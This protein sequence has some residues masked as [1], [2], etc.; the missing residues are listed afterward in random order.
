M[1]LHIAR[2]HPTPSIYDWFPRYSNSPNDPLENL[3]DSLLETVSKDSLPLWWTDH[4]YVSAKEGFLNTGA[5][6]EALRK[7]LRESRVPVIYVPDELHQHV[8]HIFNDRVLDSKQLSMF[9]LNKNSQISQWT[10]STKK[11][12]LNYL[13]SEPGFTDIG[14]LELF[15]F[16]DGTYRSIA[17]YSAFICRNQS[18]VSLFNRQ[19][20]HNIDIDKLSLAT[21]SILHEWCSGSIG[22]RS[23]SYRSASE[24]R[25]YFLEYVFKGV[26]REQDA[27][28]LDSEHAEYISQAWLW[29]IA[30]DIDL[31]DIIS[32][33]WLIPLT[34]G[35]YRKIKPRWSASETFLAP[36]GRVGDFMNAFDVNYSSTVKPLVKTNQLSIPARE[37]LETALG[38][39]SSLH[40]RYGGKLVDFAQWL[41]Q[42]KLVVDTAPDEE[43]NKLLEILTSCF[44]ASSTQEDYQSISNDIGSLQIFKKVSWNEKAITH[45]A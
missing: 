16:K 17:N 32:D 38:S 40:I 27:V 20:D 42:I 10:L 35:Q 31:S 7:A 11:L 33:L 9:L 41:Y 5:K 8:E 24:F 18:E 21:S 2:L 34:N 44:Q 12:V 43:K 28:R 39:V 15:P 6:S 37:R 19:E 30:Q 25:V 3:L 45:Q 26:P 14:H 22:H 1:L 23:I 4:G 36:H 29:I 13:L